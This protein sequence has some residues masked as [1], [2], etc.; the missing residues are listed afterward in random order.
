MGG[1]ENR[2]K[3]KFTH[4]E[5][6]RKDHTGRKVS[7]GFK[8]RFSLE[9]WGEFW[10]KKKQKQKEGEEELSEMEAAKF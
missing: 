7:L 2:K 5:F 4:K 3:N 8:R 10:L 6:T 1:Y 9:K